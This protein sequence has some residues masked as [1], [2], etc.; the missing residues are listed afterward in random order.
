M[1]VSRR[2]PKKKLGRLYHVLSPT[3][4]DEK[5]DCNGII[6]LRK[7]TF[8]A[9]AK[10][11]HQE[12]EEHWDAAMETLAPGELFAVL[13]QS[14]KT[15]VTNGEPFLFGTFLGDGEGLTCVPMMKALCVAK[16]EKDLRIRMCFGMTTNAVPDGRALG[17]GGIVEKQGISDFGKKV[18]QLG[19]SNCFEE[20]HNTV[21]KARTYLQ[22]QLNKAVPYGEIHENP[23]TDRAP[24]DTIIYDEQM[25]GCIWVKR[26]NTALERFYDGLFPTP[27]FPSDHAIVCAKFA[28]YQEYGK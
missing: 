28:D 22:A 17:E 15:K 9:N 5:A 11:V 23:K 4:F 10:E 19:L 27:A 20:P 18:K 7:S 13:A 12:I 6:L 8:E 3:N 1:R 24:K 21:F 2:P 26:D 14:K 16:K 25:Q